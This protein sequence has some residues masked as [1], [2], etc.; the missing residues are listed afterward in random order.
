LAAFALLCAG[1]AA[2]STP[3][4]DRI[5][6]RFNE[7]TGVGGVTANAANPGVG[8]AFATV[9]G[10]TLAPTGGVT[11]TGALVAA[12]PAATTNFVNTGWTTAFGAGSWTI[13]F[14]ADV[15]MLPTGTLYYVFGDSTAGSF[16]AFY[17][18]AAGVATS[19]CAAASPTSTSTEPGSA[20]RT[21]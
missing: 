9:T 8:S 2:Q 6:Y 1:V 15:S 7:G 12:T 3:F 17:N 19:C 5:Y 10:H 21:P 14:R 16:R 20:V 11:G 18:G 13:S 4:P